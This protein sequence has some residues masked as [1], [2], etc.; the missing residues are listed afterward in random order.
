MKISSDILTKQP[1]YF[2]KQSLAFISPAVLVEVHRHRCYQVAITLTS[3]FDCLIDGLKLKDLKGIIVNQNIPHAC[4]VHAGDVLVSFIEADSYWGRQ[5]RACLAG[6]SYVNLADILEPVTFHS[7][8]PEN[9]QSLSNQILVPY[10]NSFFR[11]L[12]PLAA[13]EPAPVKWH[14][15]G[16][17]QGNPALPQEVVETDDRIQKALVYIHQHLYER[18]IVDDM[19]DHIHLSPVRARH[20]F[21]EETGTPF[22]QYVLWQRIKAIL[23]ATLKGDYTLAE[24]CIEYGFVDQPHFNRQ[25]KQIFGTSPTAL[26]KGGRILF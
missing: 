12:L 6:R 11:Q 1:D 22:S 19:A 9:Y 26:L 16:Q 18:L 7:L 3:T 25:F 5:L 14:F 20:L 23:K 10:I 8:F 4:R 17:K 13:S 24:A 21:A 2:W 15:E